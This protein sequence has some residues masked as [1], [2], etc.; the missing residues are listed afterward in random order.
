MSDQIGLGLEHLLAGAIHANG[1]QLVFDV[2]HILSE[3]I[4][5]KQI[6]ITVDDGIATIELVDDEVDE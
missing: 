1:G 5:G 2:E 3:D 4:I 6:A